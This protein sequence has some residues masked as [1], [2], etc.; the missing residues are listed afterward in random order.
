RLP[1]RRITGEE[2]ALRFIDE[3]GFCAAF[4][5]G[6]G[7]PCLR[8]AIEGRREPEL[9]HHIQH[10][11]AIMMTWNLKDALPARRA[12][13]YG[14]VLGGRPGFIALDLLPCFLRLRVAPG[15]YRQLY[16]RGLLSHCVKLVM[17]A[18]SRSGLSE[19][20]ALKVTTSL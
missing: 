19:N 7:L 2:T 1:A 11:R 20:K 15:G 12:V 16:Q 10:D 13:Y 3:T 9:P 17:E 5:A 14:K 18:L 8:E 6:L 4:T